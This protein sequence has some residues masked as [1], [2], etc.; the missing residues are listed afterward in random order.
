MAHF[1]IIYCMQSLGSGNS[2]LGSRYSLF[3][4][5]EL[6]QKSVSKF[7]S[8]VMHHNKLIYNIDATRLY[9]RRMHE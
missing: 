2:I 7:R 8:Q 9:C 3:F 1:E 5:L 4:F 6:V